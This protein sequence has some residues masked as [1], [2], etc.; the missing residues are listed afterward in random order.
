VAPERGAAGPEDWVR[1]LLAAGSPGLATAEHREA[2][3]RPGDEEAQA[4]E[5]A[6]LVPAV[7]AQ[8]ARERPPAR[9]KPQAVPAA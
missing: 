8:G 9:R 5:R 3:T 4:E 1:P 6:E 2:Q 7:S